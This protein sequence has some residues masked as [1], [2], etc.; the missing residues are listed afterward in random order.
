MF[1]P[2]VAVEPATA[3]IVLLFNS[4]GWLN[5]PYAPVPE[6]DPETAFAINVCILNVLFPAVLSVLLSSY[7]NETCKFV[8]PGNKYVWN[9]GPATAEPVVDVA[10]LAA[11]NAFKFNETSDWSK[12]IMRPTFNAS[13]I[14]R[15]VSNITVPSESLK[16][17]EEPVSLPSFVT[18]NVLDDISN[19]PLLPLIN[20]ELGCPRKNLVV[21]MSNSSSYVLYRK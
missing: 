1:A 21:R 17:A 18:W 13:V 16:I 10:E 6:F 15:V 12:C 7:V 14:W 11:G 3:S 8:S 20:D 19:S 2:E 5:N 4:A 9:N